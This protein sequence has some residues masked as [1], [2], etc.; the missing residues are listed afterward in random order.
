MGT[1]DHDKA[2]PHDLARRPELRR[3]ST[4]AEHALWRLLR[5]RQLS[6]AKFHRQYQAG[7]YYLDFYC[8][9]CRFAIELDGAQHHTPEGVA[10]DLVRS[11]FLATTGIR[12]IRFSDREVLTVRQGVLEAIM[13][14][15][16]RPSP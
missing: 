12:V 7:P 1:H 10:R 5:D 16:A 3:N 8:H 6:W 13:R 9:G 4:D 11:A 15:L 14:E 2:D